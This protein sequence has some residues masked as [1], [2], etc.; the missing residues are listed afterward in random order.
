MNLIRC[1]DLS[2]RWRLSG[3]GFG[4]CIGIGRASNAAGRAALVQLGP[5]WLSAGQECRDCSG[6]GPAIAC[7][8]VYLAIRCLNYLKF[9]PAAL[10]L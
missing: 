6:C 4:L 3:L 10:S 7:G 9:G 5:D 2:H 1:L 8:F